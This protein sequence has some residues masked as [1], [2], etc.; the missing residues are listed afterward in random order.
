VSHRAPPGTSP[1]TSVQCEAPRRRV[2]V[3]ATM[4]V[5]HHDHEV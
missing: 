2:M 5:T 3:N 1:L 4:K